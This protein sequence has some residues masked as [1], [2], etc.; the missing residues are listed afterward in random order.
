MIFSYFTLDIHKIST[1]FLSLINDINYIHISNKTRLTGW[2]K[3]NITNIPK[4]QTHLKRSRSPLLA[5][6]PYR[7]HKSLSRP[8]VP[9]LFED[10]AF[11]YRQAVIWCRTTRRFSRYGKTN[12]HF[13]E[14]TWVSTAFIEPSPPLVLPF[15]VDLTL[16]SN[17]YWEKTVFCAAFNVSKDFIPSL[18]GN[19][20]SASSSD[21]CNYQVFDT[22]FNV[23]Q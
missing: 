16:T 6:L 8:S 13:T 1:L 11:S 4:S 14:F 12:K 21:D 19:S 9:D 7:W 5:C 22:E 23:C 10:I 17:Q 3:Q 2:I 18:C 20:S 15:H